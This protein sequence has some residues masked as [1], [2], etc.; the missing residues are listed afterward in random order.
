MARALLL[1][2]AVILLALG[3]HRE[4]AHL[5]PP[6]HFVKDAPRTTPSAASR[7]LVRIELPQ[8]WSTGTLSPQGA[9]PAVTP[10]AVTLSR[11]ATA[12]VPTSSQLQVPP[13]MT[14]LR[15]VKRDQGIYD[16]YDDRILVI[17]HGIAVHRKAAIAVAHEDEWTVRVLHHSGKPMRFA[18][19]APT[20]REAL[21]LFEDWWTQ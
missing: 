8:P 1:L 7:S 10:S 13:R 20:R 4:P 3:L 2:A 11:P 14:A 18:F 17:A 16:V 19:T 21:Q 9:I 5:I 12:A 15:L 6:T